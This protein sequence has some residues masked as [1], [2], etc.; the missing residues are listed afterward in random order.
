MKKISSILLAAI[1]VVACNNYEKGYRHVAIDTDL[2]TVVLKL[3]N[4]TPNHRDNFVK[5]ANEKFFN[6]TIFH[7]VI[8]DF[9]IQGGDPS[10]KNAQKGKIYGADDAGYLLDAEF[11]NNIYHKRGALAMAREGDNVN[12]KKKS[13]SSQFYIVVGKKFT[14]EELDEIEKRMNEQ[15][16][17]DLQLELRLDM[18]LNEKDAHNPEVVMRV[19]EIVQRKTDSLINT[20]FGFKF[21]EEQREIYTTIGGTPHLDG[22]YPVFG[23]VVKGMD[24]VE[25][26]SKL[27]TD[28]HDRPTKDIKMKVKVIN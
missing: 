26:I 10:S 3:Y 21:S 19:N 20:G 24:I 4:E 22:A 16:I 18:L 25:K 2:G 12:P 6:G 7:R 28:K 1:T 23:E 27:P 13:S 8:K 17:R 5:L 9:M 15:K 11:V 14:H